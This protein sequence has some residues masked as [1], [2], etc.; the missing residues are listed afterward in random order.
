MLLVFFLVVVTAVF[1]FVGPSEVVRNTS[2]SYP[3]SLRR[4]SRVWHR[5]AMSILPKGKERTI[6]LIRKYGRDRGVPIAKCPGRNEKCAAKKNRVWHE[7]RGKLPT[8]RLRLE[9]QI[10]GCLA[11]EDHSG[12]QSSELC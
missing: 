6:L 12:T 5:D 8:Q 7:V 2:G 11:E 9:W 4:A 1:V 10:S 3:A